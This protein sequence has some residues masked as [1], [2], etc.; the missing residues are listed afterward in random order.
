MVT[1]DASPLPV[2]NTG[3]NF[4]S[5]Q[6]ERLASR[7]GHGCGQSHKERGFDSGE[8]GEAKASP[9]LSRNCELARSR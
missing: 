6:P 9:A 4:I 7:M 2:Y 8:A 5:H 3:H 1:L